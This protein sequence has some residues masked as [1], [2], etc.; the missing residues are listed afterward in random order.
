MYRSTFYLPLHWWEVS[1]QLHAPAALPLGK[2]A[3]VGTRAGLGY[4]EKLKFLTSQGLKLRPFGRPA[5]SYS[6]CRLSYRGSL[7][8][9]VLRKII[10]TLKKGLQ[11]RY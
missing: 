5:R 11:K 3:L 6:L 2:E 7:E 1:G 9:R 8:N 10:G 4:M